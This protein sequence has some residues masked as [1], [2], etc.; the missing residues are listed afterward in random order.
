M[1]SVK[2][3]L[4]IA[5]FYIFFLNMAMVRELYFIFLNLEKVN[6]FFILSVFFFF[7][8]VFNIVFTCFSIKYIEKPFF[9]LLVLTSSLVN[10][11]MFQYKTIFDIDMMANIFETNSAEAGAYL[12]WEFI[13]WFS[14]TGI[15][16]AIIILKCRIKH[17]PLLKEI[18]LK[19]LS[20]VIS[21]AVIAFI[22]MFFYKDYA[23]VI[24]NNSSLRKQIVPSYYVTSATKYFYQK[25][26]YE[27]LPYK[28]IGLDAKHVSTDKNN[29][30]VFIVGETARAQN[31][32]L[33][34][35]SRA[36][37]KYSKDIDNLIAFQNVTSCGTA[38]AV[39]LPCM[40][41]MMDRKNYSLREFD[42]Q[43]NVVDIMNRAGIPMIWKENNTGCKGVCRNIKE[44][45]IPNDNSRYCDGSVCT[46]D[47]FL[48]DLEHDIISMKETGGIIFLHIMGSHGPTYF[49]RVPDRY[50]HFKPE[51]D[52]SDIQNCTDEE[53]VNSYDD[54]IL[55]TD[56][57]MAQT[58]NIL[59][60]HSDVLNTSML[61]VSD[62]G[63][64][65]G[66]NGLYL[67]GMPYSVAPETQNHVP[68]ILWMDNG[69]LQSE[70]IDMKCLKEKA[71]KG[72]FSHDN[73]SHT[74]LGLMNVS[75]KVHDPNLD[76]L[77]GCRQ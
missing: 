42:S 9:I 72:D 55:F 70:N 53:I 48:E 11:A 40:F 46:D 59:K 29:L 54:T 1:H 31:Y 20:V 30:L 22:A 61:Y 12:N 51:C 44:I 26:F 65:L 77:E 4:S 7:I 67:H 50:K 24:R 66:E 45:T 62:H 2:F 16:P 28:E 13:I 17:S 39:S 21:L 49:K 36:T 38:T 69:T 43:D 74:L 18:A 6:T 15:L 5:V 71:K 52:R 33:N 68:L 19:I 75:T 34:G 27:P 64:S 60:Q 56:Y 58:I 57:M 73:L 37:N 76:I 10:F 32:Q 41:S 8:T 23:S 14:V 35:Y 47:V 25:Y 3:T 63:E